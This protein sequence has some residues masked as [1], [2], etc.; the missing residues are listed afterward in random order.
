MD[1]EKL[2]LHESSNVVDLDFDRLHDGERLRNRNRGGLGA[3][4]NFLLSIQA[5]ATPL[6]LV[7][8]GSELRANCEP[9]S[10]LGSAP[11]RVVRDGTPDSLVERSMRL[12]SPDAD[13][14]LLSRLGA[15]E[16]VH[17]V[18]LVDDPQVAEDLR[19]ENGDLRDVG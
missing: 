13:D 11:P 8:R 14:L 10:V 12:D 16:D 19:L 9:R 3:F 5:P 18:D 1:L 4:D 6:A 7:E 2:G 17:E 15:V